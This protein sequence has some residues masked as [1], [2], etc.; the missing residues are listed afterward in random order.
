MRPKTKD[1]AQ[2]VALTLS[3]PA[4]NYLM[5]EALRRGVSR[6]QVVE[7]LIVGLAE[8]QDATSKGKSLARGGGGAGNTLNPSD[9]GLET[10]PDSNRPP[11]RAI[12][13]P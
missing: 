12:S 3:A 6:T 13:F 9:G 1:D 4:R 5:S 2:K 11:E 8:K 10:P 7:D